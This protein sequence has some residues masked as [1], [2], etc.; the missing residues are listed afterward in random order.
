[1]IGVLVGDYVGSRFEFAPFKSKDFDLVHP[2]CV[3]TDD[4][5]MTVALADAIARGDTNHAEAMRRVGR[6]H[7]TSYGPAFWTWL[8][9]PEMGPYGSWAN[10]SSMRVSPAA[11]FARDIGECLELARATAEVTHDHPEGVRGAQATAAAIFAAR[12]GWS[13]AETRAMVADR[14]GYPM[15]EDV[16]RIREHAVFELKS[17]ISVPQALTC[18]F[19]ATS[20]EDAIRNAVSIGGDADTQAAI[21]GSVAQWWFP[22]PDDLRDAALARLPEEIRDMFLAAEAKAVASGFV[23]LDREGVDAIP[24]WDPDEV[25]R[26]LERT[27]KVDADAARELERWEEIERQVNAMP[28]RRETVRERLSRAWRG[29]RSRQ[30]R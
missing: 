19:E 5:L 23:P 30:A 10:G 21:A 3:Y 26:W 7:V 12:S 14:F 9:T 2:D 6:E 20:F 13:Q 22:V 15:D 1:M 29:W 8:T 11:V 16:D 4:S 27:G 28:P 17:W 18:A 25:R 24:R